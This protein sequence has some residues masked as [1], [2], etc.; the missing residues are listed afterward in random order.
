MATPSKNI[1]SDKKVSIVDLGLGNV[2]SVSRALSH[3]G[4]S[5]CV[6]SAIQDI[7]ASDLIIFPGVGNYFEASK[8]LFESEMAACLKD[9]VLTKGKPLL[10][11]CLG[12]QLLADSGEEGGQ[13]KGLGL[14]SGK[15]KKIDVE[16]KALLLPHIGW[17]DVDKKDFKLLQGIEEENPCFYFVHSYA[18]I[19][20][21]PKAEFICCNYGTKITAAVSK[22]N[23]VGTQFHPEKS[24][25]NGLTVL[26]NFVSGNY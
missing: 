6:T 9:Q 3:I 5:N 17:N 1:S 7:V 12:M 8:R 19:V 11:I 22:G 4:I 10:G 15:I 13:S 2:T 24:Q 21:D 26:R 25:N 20:E 14:I 23:I 16:Q 18:M